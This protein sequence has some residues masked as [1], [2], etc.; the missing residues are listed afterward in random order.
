MIKFRKG[1]IIIA[2][3]GSEG[4]VLKRRTPYTWVFWLS[5]L[6]PEIDTIMF[7]TPYTFGGWDDAHV[8]NENKNLNSC[9]KIGTTDF[10][11]YN[12]I[13]VLFGDNSYE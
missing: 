7:A 4:W 6:K 2:P 8:K 1:D 13:K 12:K 11:R 3:C 5:N 10:T 9:K